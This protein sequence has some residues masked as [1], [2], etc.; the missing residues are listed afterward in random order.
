MGVL[1]VFE[2]CANTQNNLMY[3]NKKWPR[4]KGVRDGRRAKYCCAYSCQGIVK[5][6]P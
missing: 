2:G 1:K 3:G 5:E 6:P 4:R